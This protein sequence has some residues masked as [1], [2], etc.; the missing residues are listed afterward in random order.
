MKATRDALLIDLTD[1]P[2]PRGLAPRLRSSTAGTVIATLAMIAALW[3]GQRFLIPLAAGLMLA[4]LVMPQAALL[5]GLLRSRVAAA[6]LTLLLVMG[7]LTVGALAFGGQLV[8]VA[9]R[10][11]EMISMAAQQISAR[12]PGAHSVLRRARDALQELDRAADRVIADKPL[13][14]PGRRAA[15]IAAS[16]PASAATANNNITEGATEALRDTAV[17]GSSFLLDF[18][19]HLSI[20]FFIAFFVLTG[21]KPLTERFLGLWSY[22]PE[23]H[24][25]AHHAML[26]CARQIR[27]YAGVLLVTNTALGVA[28]WAAFSLAG[29]P[30]AAGWGVT[31]AVLH[32]VPYLGMALLTGLGAAETF[33]AHETVGAALGM[34][35]FLV[36]LSTVVG[37]LV[38]AW[39]QGRSAKMNPAA[40]FIG[41][42]FWGALWGVWGLFLGPVLAVVL[43]VVAEHSRCG[44]RLARLMQG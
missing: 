40:V 7:A 41:L 43:K 15:A 11:P 39:L 1:P 26:E 14:R 4:M 5:E 8:R 20:I 27:I 2:P 21:G 3:W 33:L 37:T 16:I 29:L 31:A 44:V 9:E 38:T 28:V 42:M 17:T 25:H 36:A 6:V 10:V 12:D 22:H 35:A 32:V 19:G 30:D 18:A 34:A 13:L 24:E 23:V